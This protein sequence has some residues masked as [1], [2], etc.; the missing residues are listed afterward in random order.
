MSIAFASLAGG[1]GG[2]FLFGR[3]LK[4]FG[5][6]APTAKAGLGSL[7][8]LSGLAK[9]LLFRCF[10]IAS[11]SSWPSSLCTLAQSQSRDDELLVVE[12][13]VGGSLGGFFS[14]LPFSFF[15]GCSSS[16]R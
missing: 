9:R 16:E 7:V 4:M 15:E 11:S 10:S 12:S 1:G 13:W 2:A 5:G 8:R 6:K 3:A 14:L